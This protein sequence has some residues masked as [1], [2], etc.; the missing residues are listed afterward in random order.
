[1]KIIGEWETP[2][3]VDCQCPGDKGVWVINNDYCAECQERICQ[4]ICPSGIFKP[5]EDQGM[6][7]DNNTVCLECG[8]CRLICDNIIF[9]YPQADCGIIHRFG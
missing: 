9:E 3:S 6:E 5:T 8:A 1:M 2:T 7:F 4:I